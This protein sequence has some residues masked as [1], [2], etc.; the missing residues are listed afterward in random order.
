MQLSNIHI[1]F[2]RFLISF[3]MIIH[4]SQELRY[5]LDG[6][7]WAKT[8]SFFSET[9]ENIIMGENYYVSFI[10]PDNSSFLSYFLF[11]T[12]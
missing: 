4:R 11:I 2:A 8:H 7:H 5:T 12:E 10:A 6:K 1:L 3:Q 9:V